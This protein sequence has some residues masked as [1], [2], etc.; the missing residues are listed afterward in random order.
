MCLNLGRDV[1]PRGAIRRIPGEERRDG[2]KVVGVVRSQP[3]DPR[4]ATKI[5]LETLG[6]S[7]V[8]W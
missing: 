3:A 2:R 7:V 4:V 5:D 8:L 1:S 6:R